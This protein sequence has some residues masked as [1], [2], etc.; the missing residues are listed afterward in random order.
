MAKSS[1]KKQKSLIKIIKAA[2]SD[3]VHCEKVDLKGSFRLPN[4]KIQFPVENYPL[5]LHIGQDAHIL[6]LYPEHSLATSNT[7]IDE[8]SYILF[9]PEKYYNQISGFFR[10]KDGDKITLGHGDNQQRTFLNTPKKLPERQLSISNDE[11]K[12]IFKCHHPE[13]GSCISP[14][15]KDKKINKVSDWRK[16]K[17]THLAKILGDPSKKLPTKE[18]MKLIQDVNNIMEK[19]AYREKDNNGKPGGVLCIPE[20]LHAIIIGDLH[21]RLD[22]LLTILSQ[23]NFLDALDNGKACL[24]ILGDAVHPEIEGQYDQ[25]ES[26]QLMMDVLFQLKIRFPKQVFYIRGNHDSFS[27]EIGKKG[28]PQGI[29]WAKQLTKERGKAYKKEMQRF[30]DNLPY[31]AYSKNYITCHASPPTSSV[32]LEDLVNVKQ[33]PKLIADLTNKRFKTPNRMSGYNKGDIKKLRS[34]LKRADNTAFIVGHTPMNTEE[35]LWENVGDINNHYVVYGGH[36]DWI[37]AMVE[38]GDNIY[39]LLYPVEPLTEQL[40]ALSEKS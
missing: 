4:K 6:H 13:T 18:A 3:L 26:S 39:P 40:K 21:T 25:M 1:S 12:L 35:T 34:S 2:F 17:L 14:L 20:K 7:N 28:V 16:K 22:N 15:F 9:D 33:H 38:M 31:L 8:Q 27:E 32:C 29:L 37:G 11:G 24:I 30:Y 10:L 5:Q 23:N 36:P 19:E